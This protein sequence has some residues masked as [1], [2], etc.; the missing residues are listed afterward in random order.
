MSRAFKQATSLR[1]AVQIDLL[2]GESASLV[3]QGGRAV[4]QANLQ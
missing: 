4:L 1:K 2:G 3:V